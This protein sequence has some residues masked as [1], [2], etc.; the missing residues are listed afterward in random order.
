MCASEMQVEN[1]EAE[2]GK[3]RVQENLDEISKRAKVVFLASIFFG[4]PIVPWFYLK[5]FS[6]TI[7]LLA[8]I[9]E[10]IAKAIESQ[11]NEAIEQI[12]KVKSWSK[13]Y[14]P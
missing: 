6:D 1:D 5:F 7:V 12:E 13:L 9:S 8:V 4:N 14:I 10:G 2:S 3:K 11:N